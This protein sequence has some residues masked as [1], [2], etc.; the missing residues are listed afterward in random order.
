MPLR[1]AYR[2]SAYLI[3]NALGEIDLQ[4]SG[5]QISANLRL[6]SLFDDDVV[7][8]TPSGGGGGD[9]TSDQLAALLYGTDGTDGV[10]RLSSGLSFQF[11]EQNNFFTIVLRS[12]F[13]PVP[14]EIDETGDTFFYFGWQDGD[15]WRVE[16][17]VRATSQRQLAMMDN[18]PS[19]DDLDEA[20]PDRFILTYE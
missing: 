10:L 19:Y 6:T 5:A 14:T 20:W 11:D 7:P 18:N 16:R 9:V 2:V 1:P 8:G 4:S 3:S 12:P 13:L 15:F 17:Q